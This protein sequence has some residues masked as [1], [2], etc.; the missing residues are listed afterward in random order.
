MLSPEQLTM[1]L[2][3][4]KTPDAADCLYAAGFFDGE[5]SV[6]IVRH[7]DHRKRYRYRLA[8]IVNNTVLLPL[9]WLC[10]RWGGK[11]Y[12]FRPP[13][14]GFRSQSWQWQINTK[15]RQA[16]FLEDLRPYMK[17]KGPAT[18]NALAFLRLTM[19]RGRGRLTE[20]ALAEQAAYWNEHKRIQ[21]EH[22]P[23]PNKIGTRD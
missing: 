21:Y 22:R 19:R 1:E 15:D 8:I 20:T 17:I 23:P 14:I 6:V 7:H 13:G 2:A 9:E 18:D 3:P 16:A 4:R 12:K 10:D 5:G 11:V